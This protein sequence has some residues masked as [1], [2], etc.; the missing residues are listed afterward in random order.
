MWSWLLK[1][2]PTVPPLSIPL[3]RRLS[4]REMTRRYVLA[5]V[6]LVIFSLAQSVLADRVKEASL[7]AAEEINL[8]G[9]QRSL[10]QQIGLASYAL[11]EAK[12]PREVS[13]AQ[14]Q[15]RVAATMLLEGHIKLLPGTTSIAGTRELSAVFFEPVLGQDSLNVM[16]RSAVSEAERLAALSPP[17]AMSV[18][19]KRDAQRLIG[20]V[21]GP[22]YSALDQAVDALRQ[23]KARWQ[24]RTT[25]LTMVVNAGGIL[26][27]ICIGL[28]MFRP[29]VHGIVRHQAKLN[30]MMQEAHDA[31][32]RDGLTWLP[33]R[34]FLERRLAAIIEDQTREGTLIGVIHVE[35]DRLQ[36]VQDALGHE[37]ADT[38]LCQLAER[39]K[40]DAGPEDL[41]GRI[42]GRVF[43]IVLS[44]L[45]EE[46][47]ALSLA[48]R[49]V[50][51]VAE[52]IALQDGACRVTAF[53]GAAADSVDTVTAP[54]LMMDASLA[55]SRARSSYHRTGLYTPELRRSFEERNKVALALK[56]A[57]ECGQIEPWFQPQLDATTGRLLG[58]EALVRWNDPERGPQNASR[59]LSVAEELGLIRAVDDLVRRQSLDALCAMRE[60]GIELPR[61][62]LNVTLAQLC[63]KGFEDRLL[64][65][66]QSAGLMPSDIALELLETVFTEGRQE[67]VASR[68]VDL[69]EAGF[70]VELDDF[71]TGHSALSALRDL[72]VHRVKIDS[73]F[74]HDVHRRPQ[75]ARFTGAL[76]SLAKAMEID[77]L[78]EG[79]ER[80][81]ERAWLENAGC[82]AMQG[83]L[84]AKPM[85]LEP[86]IDWAKQRSFGDSET[87]NAVAT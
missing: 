86:F 59:F 36:Q 5:I 61:L 1:A 2:D 27:A 72:K 22:L 14:E 29:M 50:Q 83:F 15:L 65:D 30:A 51:I 82:H 38:V 21:D 80:E 8:A 46:E 56:G 28:F 17:A 64:Y 37:A 47:E 68:V 79:V 87:K 35:I 19:S 52:P 53:A 34:Q 44:D 48:A 10:A 33:N 67:G 7:V 20:R 69:A 32:L 13:I 54:Q 85:S 45:Y 62:G 43:A 6:L 18:A 31:A 77:V 11:I 40:K 63:E 42:D 9:L 49:I 78:S 75:V 74:V 16:L 3:R 71:G 4:A 26:L 12:D 84:F 39:L 81:G 70:Y 58:V 66:I 57:I 25:Q 73:S 76:I 60:A 23:S 55:L 41:V 24:A